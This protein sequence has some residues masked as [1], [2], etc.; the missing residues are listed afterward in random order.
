MSGKRISNATLGQQ[1]AFD[2]TLKLLVDDS[3]WLQAKAMELS[4]LGNTIFQGSSDGLNYHNE[5]LAGD[6]YFRFSTDG[7]TEYKLL[8]TTNVQEGSNLYYTDARVNANANVVANTLHSNSDGSDHAFIDQDVTIGSA[9]V[10]DASNFTNLPGGTFIGLDDTPAS[11]AGQIGKLLQVNIAGNALEYIAKSSMLLTDFDD[12]G[13]T[14]S[15]A[16]ITDFQS[17]VTNNVSVLANTA[18]LTNYSNPHVVTAAQLGL[19]NVTNNKQIKALPSVSDNYVPQWDGTSGDTLKNGL[20]VQTT[21]TDSDVHIGT[22]GA[23]MDYVQAEIAGLGGG[24]GGGYWVED[25]EGINYQAGNVGIGAPSFAGYSLKVVGSGIYGAYVESDDLYGIFTTNTY[26]G[27]SS[28]YGGRFLADS[29][30]NGYGVYASGSK[31]GGYFSNAATGANLVGVGGNIGSNAEAGSKAVYGSSSST[32]SSHY[33]GFFSA[34]SGTGGIGVYGTGSS[35]GGYFLSSGTYG[36]RSINQSTTGPAW[37]GYFQSYSQ[38]AAIGLYASCLSAAGEDSKAI[39]GSNPSSSTD[40]HYGGYFTATSGSNGVGTHS[41]GSSIDYEAHGTGVIELK[42]AGTVDTPSS[43]YG[44]LYTKDDLPYF[45]DDNGTEYNLASQG[46]WT[47]DT[48]GITYANNV[49]IGSASEELVKLNVEGADVWGIDASNEAASKS[50]IR[51]INS[52]TTGN[53]YAGY[54]ESRSEG[55]AISL[56][57]AVPAAGGSSCR[58]IAGV[59]SSTASIAYG[60]HFTATTATTGYGVYG[61][62]SK[63]GTYGRTT[64]QYGAVGSTTSSDA[65]V[66]GVYGSLN[67]GGSGGKAVYGLNSSSTTLTHYG[68]YFTANAGSNGTGVYA[69]GSQYGGSFSTN[70]D[71]G[72]A[73]ASNKTSGTYYGGYFT[74]DGGTN[75]T[76]LYASGSKEAAFFNGAFTG[77]ELDSDPSNPAEGNYT[78]WM[79]DGTGSGDDGDIMIKITA[80]GSTKTITLIDFSAF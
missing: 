15:S 71:Y 29:G 78:I 72:I 26:D 22:S 7:G 70:G 32:A 58:A 60:G 36:V 43:G 18:H 47:E 68:G 45:K 79:S 52:S 12:T 5:I 9:P 55:L 65:N 8:N 74:A 56:Y 17:A 50:A 46:L 61:Y 21:L 57:A 63:Y 2:G 35:S 1:T 33:G 75:G 6:S 39:Q 59:N 30:T 73:A 69:N 31:Y 10:F 4:L 16:E 34:T 64:G 25:T 66:V 40:P 67:N 28:H 51:G 42:D 41:E 11:Y 24:G 14:L 49:S 53:A 13:F 80:G 77:A 54:F 23:I 44:R 76:G 27:T 48:Y 62:G 20:G 3:V 37:A 19:G 38:E